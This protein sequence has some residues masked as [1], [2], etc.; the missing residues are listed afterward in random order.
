MAKRKTNL[1]P[2]EKQ[3][4]ETSKAY[5]AFCAYRDMGTDRSLVKIIPITHP[6]A[7]ESGNAAKIKAKRD[8]L[9]AWSSKYGWVARVEAYDVYLELKERHENEL[10]IK[11]MAKRHAQASLLTMK[12]AV[13]RIKLIGE[14][15]IEELTPK[16][17][18]DYLKVAAELERKSRGAP[19]QI[20]E[21]G[22]EVKGSS[23]IVYLPDNG[24]DADKLDDSE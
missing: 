23:V 18:L 7:Y 8:Q 4:H 19:D 16:E 12:K 9:A 22:G 11:K 14:K 5:A 20:V 6:K 17:A 24:R 10:E 13:D 15:D 3:E 1:D 21:L 2:W